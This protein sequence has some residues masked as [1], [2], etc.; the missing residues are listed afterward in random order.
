MTG[1]VAG[2][3]ERITRLGQE[4]GARIAAGKLTIPVLPT[5]A[6]E[7]LRAVN[8]PSADMGRLAETIR[9]DQALAG[10]VMK[11]ANSPLLRSG[12]PIVSLQQAIARL[13]MRNVA[14]VALAASMGPKLFRAPSYTALVE[15]IWKESLASALWAREI[16]RS[17]RRSV[18]VGFLCALLHQVGKPVVLQVV[19]DILGPGA[20]GAPGSAAVL[21]LLEAHGSAAGLAVAQAWRLPELVTETIAHVQDFRGAP[22][23]TELVALVAAARAFAV[24]TLQGAT[25]ETALLAGSPEMAAINLYHADIVRLLEQAGA[26]RETLG[27]IAL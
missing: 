15:A 5:V 14:D 26:V 25:P 19:Q 27:A 24:L 2:A 17:L 6:T 21:R 1:S 3:E 16:A 12:M 11:F 20:A 23:N 10:H 9:N 8:D 22:R 13:G 7:V 18:E 4:I